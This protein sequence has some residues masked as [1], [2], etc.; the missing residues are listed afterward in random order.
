MRRG[1]GEGSVR[2]RGDGRWEGRV[3]FQGAGGRS[4][5]SVYGRT[6]R[7]VLAKLRAARD[8][9]LPLDG[10]EPLAAYLRRWLEQRDPRSPAAGT[11]KLR[12]TTW[13]GYDS[14]MR[15]H[16]IPTIGA[17]P[18]GKLT[19]EHVR[20]LVAKLSGACL[21]ATTVAMVRD[22]L[23]TAMR[24]AVKD[25]V[26]PFNPVEAVDAVPRS[27]RQKYRLTAEEARTLLR[28][29]A[30]EPLEALYVVTLRAGL[31]Q[32][33]VLGLRWRD[34][35]LEGGAL[36]VTSALVRV[37]GQGLRDFD[38][39]SAAS[40]ATIPLPPAAIAALRAQ[41]TRQ[42][43]L[44][45]RAGA[46][47]QDTGY[48]FTTELGTPISAS[49]LLRRSF[50]PLC[51]RAGIPTRPGLRFHD[52]RHACG[53]LLIAEGVKPK[54]VQAILRHSKL[55]TTMDL[56]VHAYDEDLRGAVGALDRALG[57]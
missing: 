48:V 49:N 34:V 43:E 17:V 12:Y 37:T 10:T 53:S 52:L 29:A 22:T 40:A 13:T 30:G 33:E 38:P 57:S 18:I 28:A 5:S 39:K 15:R 54:L 3:E 41:R 11:K 20:M 26:I 21:S 7:D 1:N 51:A 44:R 14:R 32:S 25:R 55:S 35:D 45:F 2:R 4:R 47:W 16:V 36:S 23:S 42:L 6:Q 19:P 24:R 9:A 46:M 27:R 56:Y 31:R 8:G 50:Y